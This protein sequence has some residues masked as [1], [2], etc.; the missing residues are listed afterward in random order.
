VL[1]EVYNR[2]AQ[3]VLMQWY[4]LK[5]NTLFCTGKKMKGKKLKTG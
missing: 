5:E 3:K 2:W 1:K 4:I